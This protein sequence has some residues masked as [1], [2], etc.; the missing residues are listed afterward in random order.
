M[1]YAHFPVRNGSKSTI[2]NQISEKV[3]KVKRLVKHLFMEKVLLL[4][5]PKYK[6]GSKCSPCLS[7]SNG[8]FIDSQQT[9]LQ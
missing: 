5:L 2:A 8:P 7:G 3:N 1:S 6:G 9:F 4:F